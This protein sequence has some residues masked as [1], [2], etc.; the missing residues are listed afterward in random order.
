MLVV[1]STRGL[2]TPDYME[3]TEEVNTIEEFRKLRA[4]LLI[5]TSVF[6]K[7]YRLVRNGFVELSAYNN[8]KDVLS[9]ILGEITIKELNARLGD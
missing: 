8:E 6:I 5:E 1:C 4:I 7:E 2:M 3:H 9:Y